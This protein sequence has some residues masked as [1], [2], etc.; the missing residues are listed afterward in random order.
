MGFSM[1]REHAELMH[2]VVQAHKIEVNGLESEVKALK[3][4]NVSLERLLETKKEIAHQKEV[5]SGQLTEEVGVLRR[6]REQLGRRVKDVENELADLQA[7]NKI[8]K[9]GIEDRER[10]HAEQFSSLN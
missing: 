3:T 1:K 10:V 6:E 7:V 8:L 5:T 9:E 2:N 4:K